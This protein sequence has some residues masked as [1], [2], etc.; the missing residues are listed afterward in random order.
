MIY[1]LKFKKQESKIWTKI[2]TNFLSNV[3]YEQ[4][5][6]CEFFGRGGRSTLG[7]SLFVSFWCFKLDRNPKHRPGKSSLTNSKLQNLTFSI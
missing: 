5:V 7:G 1:Y 6:R 4:N 3:F 2:S